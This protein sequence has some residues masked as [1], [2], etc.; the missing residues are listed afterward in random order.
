MIRALRAC[1]AETRPSC[2]A[3]LPRA[4]P[5]RTENAD[6]RT[7]RPASIYARRCP[8][9]PRSAV[10]LQGGPQPCGVQLGHVR[11]HGFAAAGR[12]HGLALV[13]H[14]QHQF[15]GV[16]LAVTEQLLEHI[17]HIVHQIDG[18]IPDDGDPRG[19]RRLDGIGADLLAGCRPCPRWGDHAPKDTEVDRRFTP[20]WRHRVRHNASS[21]TD[22]VTRVSDCA[23]STAL[24]TD[25]Y[26]LTMLAAALADGTAHRQ[27]TFEVFA[28][29]LPDGRRFGVV[30]GTGRFIDALS[31]F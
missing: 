9:P 15:R 23:G 19:L 26:E 29:R 6:R 2:A 3:W 14:L 28:R 11:L 24:L 27:T 4:R 17:R 1:P 25:K 21:A 10:L 20:V 22:T 5:T 12:H 8:S 7:S 18:V 30:A 13:V 31:A 16:R